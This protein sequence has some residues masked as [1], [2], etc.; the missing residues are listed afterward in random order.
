MSI[1]SGSNENVIVYFDNSN[2]FINAQ[3]FA[4][5]NFLVPFDTRCRLDMGKLL[6]LARRGRTVLRASLY[7]SEPPAL[8]T[9]WEGIRN[10]YIEVRIFPRSSWDNREKEIDTSLTADAVEA[11]IELKQEAG[12]NR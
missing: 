10:K 3:E 2:M 4:A 8:D 12:P 5:Q 11:L 9:V 1:A 7:G 6:N